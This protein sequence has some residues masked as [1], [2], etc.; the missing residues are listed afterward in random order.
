MVWSDHSIHGQMLFTSV[1]HVCNIYIY[2]HI[3]M[4]ICL[5]IYVCVCACVCMYTH[6]ICTYVSLCVYVSSWV[7]H[8]FHIRSLEWLNLCQLRFQLVKC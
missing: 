2:I 4:F 7:L 5:Y 3:Y 6:H 8:S 1:C